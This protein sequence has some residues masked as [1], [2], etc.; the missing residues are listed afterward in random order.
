MPV[1][2]HEPASRITATDIAMGASRMSF[3][4]AFNFPKNT[5]RWMIRK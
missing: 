1:K 2:R 5:L 3:H 4:L